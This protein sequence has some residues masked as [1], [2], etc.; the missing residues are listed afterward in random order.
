MSKGILAAVT[1]LLAGGMV[2]GCANDGSLLAGGLTTA[3]VTE[4]TSQVATPQQK[5]D[6]QCVALMS[7]IDALRKE[8]TPERIEKVST[9]KGSTAQ[10]KRE[11]LAKITELDKANAE[12]QSR[13]SS[14]STPQQAAAAPAVANQAVTQAATDA[15]AK[16]AVPAVQAAAPAAVAPASPATAAK[17]ATKKTV[18]KAAKKAVKPV[19]D[20]SAADAAAPVKQAA[21]AAPAAP[22]AAAAPKVAVPA[23]PAPVAKAVAPAAAPAAAQKATAQIAVP[24]AQQAATT[25]AGKAAPSFGSATSIMAPTGSAVVVTTTSGQ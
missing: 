25:A 15:A 8:G 22:T 6:P 2:A 10:V 9:G 24:A 13:C 14:L 4:P 18:A 16:A 12:F 20:K 5:V 7:K 1:A 17:Q 3:S 21:V 19:A 23:A 11:S